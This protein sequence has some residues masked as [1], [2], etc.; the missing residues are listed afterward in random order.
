MLSTCNMQLTM[1]LMD[2]PIYHKDIA[3]CRPLSPVSSPSDVNVLLLSE[4]AER[5]AD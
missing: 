3:E 5:N 4:A 2:A 1:H